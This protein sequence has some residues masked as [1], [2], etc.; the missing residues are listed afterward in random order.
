MGGCKAE[1]YQQ[2]PNWIRHICEQQ[3]RQLGFRICAGTSHRVLYLPPLGLGASTASDKNP[4]L[5]LT[6]APTAHSKGGADGW[7]RDDQT[8]ALTHQSVSQVHLL[9]F[10]SPK[11]EKLLLSPEPKESFHCKG[12]HLGLAGKGS[13]SWTRRFSHLSVWSWSYFYSA[14]VVRNYTPLIETLFQNDPVYS[15]LQTAFCK[16]FPKYKIISLLWWHATPSSSHS[17]PEM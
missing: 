4:V 14:L 7:M 6:G 11:E 2:V 17:F 16:C 12:D 1:Q 15:Q 13:M 3:A 10:S 5:S 9:Q 8:S